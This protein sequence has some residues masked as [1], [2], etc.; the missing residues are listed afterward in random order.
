[1]VHDEWRCL[2]QLVSL[3]VQGR[4]LERGQFLEDEGWTLAGLGLVWVAECVAADLLRDYFGMGAHVR[5]LTSSWAWDHQCVK[6]GVWEQRNDFVRVWP[7]SRESCSMD[8]S[9]V[10]IR[11]LV[12]Q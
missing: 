6:H 11:G 10:G 5:A 8:A 1:M 4:N 12:L 2:M 3:C 9:C 7:L